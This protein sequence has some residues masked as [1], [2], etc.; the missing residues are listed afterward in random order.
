M[1]YRACDL[2]GRASRSTSA[3]LCRSAASPEPLEESGKVNQAL[4]YSDSIVPTHDTAP[5]NLLCVHV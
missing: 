1:D 4:V 5:L 3:L 2:R